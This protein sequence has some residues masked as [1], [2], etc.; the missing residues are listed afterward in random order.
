[1]FRRSMFGFGPMF[2]LAPLLA[3]IAAPVSLCGGSR[4]D[5]AVQVFV[6]LTIDYVTLGIAF[7][8]Q[9][10]CAPGG[11]AILW[12]G[13]NRCEFLYLRHPR[14]AQNGPTTVVLESDGELGLGVPLGD[15]C[16]NPISWKGIIAIDAT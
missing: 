8:R 9:I 16:V 5:P 4:A 12:K 6:P 2:R 10:Y 13:T 7:K 1:M 11:R 3:A 15:Q 14:S